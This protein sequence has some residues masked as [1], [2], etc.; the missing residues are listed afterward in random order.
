MKIIFN[1]INECSLWFTTKNIHGI[2]FEW[3]GHM[4]YKIKI[5]EFEGP[6]DLLLH[7]IKKQDI[8]IFDIEVETITRQYLE[9]LHAM[10]EMNLDIASE[11][12]IVAAEL[13]EI[14]SAQLLPKPEV[15]NDT[16]EEDPRER[17]IQR[18]IEYKRYKEVMNEFRNLEEIR[19]QYYTKEV[20]DVRSYIDIETCA[21]LGDV[22]LDDLM[23]AFQKFLE[24]KEL[25][26]PLH[27]TVTKKEY[28][29]RDRSQQIKLL[30][31]NKGKLSF[32]E[33]FDILTK[34]YVVVTFLSILDLARKGDVQIVQEDNFAKIFLEGGS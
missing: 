23:G 10:K 14:K 8:D 34:E 4:E 16:Y 1:F 32:E 18:L 29:V 9:Y 26:K 6:M 7:L 20:S 11:Y 27:T 31:K 13:I 25:E 21:T 33:L 22:S 30:L 17:L 2:I 5:N 24:R 28:S 12:L 15:L 19:K 3:S